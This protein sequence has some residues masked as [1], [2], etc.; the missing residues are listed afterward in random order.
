MGSESSPYNTRD[1][2]GQHDR[3]RS[4]HLQPET[5][6]EPMSNRQKKNKDIPYESNKVSRNKSVEGG[7]REI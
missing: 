5:N 6:H 7:S 4:M 1:K 2:G 3:S